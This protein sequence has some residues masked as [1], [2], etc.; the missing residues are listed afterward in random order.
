MAPNLVANRFKRG[1]NPKRASLRWCLKKAVEPEARFVEGDVRGAWVSVQMAFVGKNKHTAWHTDILQH[2]EEYLK[3][4]MI[5]SALAIAHEYQCGG[6]EVFDI[7][8]IIGAVPIRGVLK[9]SAEVHAQHSH[10]L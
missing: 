5:H 2:R 6:P 10:G 1:E 4:R 9:R 7:K 3:G 8:Q